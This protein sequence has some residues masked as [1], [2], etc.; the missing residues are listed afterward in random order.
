MWYMDAHK[1]RP[2]MYD[3]EL[4]D[5]IGGYDDPS[6]IID[7]NRSVIEGRSHGNPH[8]DTNS[9]FFNPDTATKRREIQMY[10][11]EYATDEP[12]T[13]KAYISKVALA[14]SAGMGAYLI[15]E[16]DPELVEFGEQYI[17]NRLTDHYGA[18]TNEPRE[19]W[20]EWLAGDVWAYVTEQVTSQFANG[21]CPAPILFEM[22]RQSWGY[23]YEWFGAPVDD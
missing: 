16:D 21:Y 11:A 8:W 2:D 17:H 18:L 14:M 13:A 23:P 20:P 19:T 4:D 1:W 9:I 3:Q 6:G 15:D 5:V 10:E 12:S 22:V 7:A